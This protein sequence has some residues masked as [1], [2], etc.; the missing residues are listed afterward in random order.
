MEITTVPTSDLRRMAAPYNP[1]LISDHDLVALARSM[2]EFGVVEPVVVNRK[3]NRI[4]GGHQRVKAAEASGIDQLP[5]VYVDLDETQVE[6]LFAAPPRR[7]QPS[8]EDLAHYRR[9]ERRRRRAVW[10]TILLGYPPFL[11]FALASRWL[12]PHGPPW[13]ARAN[14]E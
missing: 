2:T 9:I 6:I 8:E 10:I 11:V 14:D 1:R 5:V 4:V 13:S 3:T 12:V 7:E